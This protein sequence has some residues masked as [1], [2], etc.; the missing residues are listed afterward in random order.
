MKTFFSRSQELIELW[1]RLSN[2]VSGAG[3]KAIGK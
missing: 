1:L 2:Q 3:S